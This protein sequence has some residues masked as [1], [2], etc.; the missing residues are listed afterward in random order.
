MNKPTIQITCDEFEEKF[1]PVL[2]PDHREGDNYLWHWSLENLPAI[3]KA[4]DEK[5][6]WTLL[7]CDGTLY[8]CS[9]WHFVNRMDYIITENPYNPEEGEIEINYEF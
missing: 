7:D 5:R 2:P 8:I 4:G 9:G 1:K 6:L 3:H